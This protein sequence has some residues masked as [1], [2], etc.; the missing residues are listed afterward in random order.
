MK[1]NATKDRSFMSA[2]RPY[3]YVGPFVLFL[4]AFVVYPVL[5]LIIRSFQSWTLIGDPK[6]VGISNYT[7]NFSKREFWS[8]IEHTCTYA[9]FVVGIGLS[10]A[11][12]VAVW[13]SGNKPLNAMTRNIMFMPHI[14]SLLSVAM[15]WTWIMNKNNG[16][17][18]IVL[19][20][21]GLPSLKWI[22][23][24]DT[25]MMSVI[26]VSLWKGLGYDVML[27]Y[28][29]MQSVPAELYEAAEL[30]H[31][32]RYARFMKITIPMIS[33]QLFT[34]LITST[35]GSFKVF[36]SINI[37]TKGGPGTSTQVLV[38]YIY[39]HAFVLNK[40]GLAAAAGVVL[41]VIVGILTIVYFCGLSRKVHYQ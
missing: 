7:Y 8:A 22:D 33:P 19:N 34:L 1:V 36:E 2:I 29:A 40:I 30:D 11:L 10:L 13:L 32:S 24:S 20:F 6:W 21:F 39:K 23:S 38:Y 9:I 41:M 16:A 14:I 27:I 35:I 37:M 17:L 28:A 31:A 15:V 5:E 26:I 12:V 25:A 18:N 4:L 3:L